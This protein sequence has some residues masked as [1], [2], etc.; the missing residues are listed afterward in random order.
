MSLDD[1]E[2]FGIGNLIG[3]PVARLAIPDFANGSILT[4]IDRPL[5]K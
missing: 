5:W 3:T 2:H 1:G 4:E